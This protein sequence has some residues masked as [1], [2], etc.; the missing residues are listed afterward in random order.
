M[1]SLFKLSTAARN[2]MCDALVDSIDTGTGAGTIAIRTGSPPTNVADA[3]SGTLLGTLTFSST[4]F[5]SAST[6]AATAATITSDTNAD[7]SGD[8]GYFR[9]YKGAGGDTAAVLQGTAGNSGDSADMTF[10]VKA[11]VAGGVIAC[12]SFVI[13]VAITQ[14]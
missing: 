13:T 4:A 7:A 6:G 2:V 12:S 11:I 1:S 9:V 10:D 5:G 3:S 14:T 8:A